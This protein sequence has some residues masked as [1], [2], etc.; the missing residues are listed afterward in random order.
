MRK[1][2]EL[3]D[4]KSKRKMELS[5]DQSGLKFLTGGSLNT[6]KGKNGSVYKAYSGLC[7]ETHAI[8]YQYLP[9]KIVEPGKNYKLTMLFKFS[10]VP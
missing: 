10:I 1:V 8:N 6:I 7:L 2:V 4:K 5:T 9:S 3:V